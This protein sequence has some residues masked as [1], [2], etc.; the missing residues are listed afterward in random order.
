MAKLNLFSLITASTVV[1]VVCNPI[2]GVAQS[3]AKTC[4]ILNKSFEQPVPERVFVEKSK[5]EIDRLTE[6]RVCIKTYP[7]PDDLSLENIS[8][9][10]MPDLLKRVDQLIEDYSKK[11]FDGINP[12]TIDDTT[13]F[14]FV[15]RS[16]RGWDHKLLQ[17]YGY[18]LYLITLLRE[19]NYEKANLVIE[20][21][22]KKWTIQIRNA[23]WDGA[24]KDTYY[25]NETLDNIFSLIKYKVVAARG[26]DSRKKSLKIAFKYS[27]DRELLSDEIAFL[28]D[29]ADDFM[30]NAGCL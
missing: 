21:I 11:R 22:N 27:K 18:F 4:E 2:G 1:I 15:S 20:E 13:T 8:S 23:T 9:T 3:A 7:W 26:E 17:K 16:N 12:L 10:Q 5:T 25:S 30:L 14:K 24:D 19:D 28:G 6:K 29:P